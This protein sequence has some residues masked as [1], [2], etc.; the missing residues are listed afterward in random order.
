M[1]LART[2]SGEPAD[3]PSVKALVDATRMDATLLVDLGVRLNEDAQLADLYAIYW[4]PSDGEGP[5]VQ[6]AAPP[7][8]TVAPEN[9]SLQPLVFSIAD[10]LSADEQQQLLASLRQSGDFSTIEPMAPAGTYRA[11]VPAE[12]MSQVRDRLRGT[13][14]ITMP[15]EH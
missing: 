11:Y 13:A 5:R 14:H 12:R 4:T 15:V 8:G 3:S 10:P 1:D 7:S 6:E 2:L 9:R